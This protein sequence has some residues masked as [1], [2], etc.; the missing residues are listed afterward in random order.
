MNFFYNYITTEV[1]TIKDS[2]SDGNAA[3]LKKS[4]VLAVLS[5]TFQ[6]YGG[7]LSKIAQL[8]SF[9]DP[10]ATCYTECQPFSSPAT[11]EFLRKNSYVY[12]DHLSINFNVYKTGSIGQVHKALKL[13]D[14]SQVVLK[15]QYLGLKEAIDSDMNVVGTISKTLFG[16]AD[17][18]TALKEIREKVHEEL[19]Y[20]VELSNHSEMY[21][22]WK[23]DKYVMIPK[24]YPDYCTDRILVTEYA[25]DAVGLGEFIQTETRQ[26]V[27]DHVGMQLV[28]FVLISLLKHSLYYSDLHAGNFLIV[29]SSTWDMKPKL[30]VTDFGCVQKVSAEMLESM[31]NLYEAAR[32]RCKY[33]FL[34]VAEQFGLFGD[35][36]DT[37]GKNYLYDYIT[38][39]M[40]PFLT[41]SHEFTD[42]WNDSCKY[43]NTELMKGWRMPADFVYFN[44]LNY[45]M[46]F[47]LTQ[48]GAKGNF[49]AIIDEAHPAAI[50][51]N[52]SM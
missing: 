29:R 16:F 42:Q 32:D 43:K 8:F 23:S 5:K 52:L 36:I 26:E 3:L 12:K 7:V 25:K 14:S 27:K 46:Y 13:D 37:P 49:K 6:S 18:R 47:L 45:C 24:I 22:L 34:E 11:V 44:K 19:D 50:K 39:Q 35:K 10:N 48:L 20:G 1:E 38:I 41:S 15:V 17:L 28:R 4:S 51:G 9:D 21:S 33:D 31:V 2:E 30:C 40:T